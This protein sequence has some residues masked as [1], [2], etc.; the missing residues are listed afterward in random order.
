MESHLSSDYTNAE[1]FDQN[2]N[3]FQKDRKEGGGGVY[4]LSKSA[5]I[6][7]PLPELDTK[8]EIIW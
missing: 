6:V 1:T 7:T 2:Y 8:C 3:V 5:F 4:L